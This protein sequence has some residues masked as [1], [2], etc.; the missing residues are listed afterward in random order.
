MRKRIA[1]VLVAVALTGGINAG[2]AIADPGP[3]H[4]NNEKGLCT[5]AS[6]G[7]KKGWENKDE[8]PPPFAAFPDPS[9]NDM[10]VT[11]EEIIEYCEG[12]EQ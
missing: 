5:A 11:R 2:F 8:L 1:A 6:H 3:H 9:D 12:L 10:P 7:K 4:G